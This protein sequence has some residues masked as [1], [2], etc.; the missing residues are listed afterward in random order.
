MNYHFVKSAV[1]LLPCGFGPFFQPCNRG[2]YSHPGRFGEPARISYQHIAPESP[3]P[4][5]VN[6]ARHRLRTF[7]IT[8]PLCYD[9]LVGTAHPP[10]GGRT[11]P[12]IPYVKE[13][14]LRHKK[15]LEA[16]RRAFRNGY[17]KKW[18]N[19][20]CVDSLGNLIIP[21][22][23][24]QRFGNL[25]KANGLRH[26]RFHDLRH[27]CASFLVSSGI[28]MKQVQLFLGHSNYSTT[29]D[30][31]AHLSPNA[32]DASDATMQSL[33][34]PQAAEDGKEGTVASAACGG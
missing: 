3:V 11:L 5:P 25:L 29:A 9:A 32:L 8:Y 31:Y 6:P 15:Q 4:T 27:S 20:V 10:A 22:K 33:L 16:N 21:D 26:I 14:L 7:A 17:S 30:I 28:P 18:L 19:C 34:A 12:L 23:L 13:E 1:H 24:T 2:R